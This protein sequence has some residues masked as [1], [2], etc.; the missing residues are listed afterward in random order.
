MSYL[1]NANERDKTEERNNRYSYLIK[2]NERD[3][4]EAIIDIVSMSL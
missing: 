1:I 3:K 4:T 2:A